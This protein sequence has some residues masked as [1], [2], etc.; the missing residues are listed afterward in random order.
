MD[1]IGIRAQNDLLVWA[2]KA[3]AKFHR[4]GSEWR[5]ACPLHTGSNAN[6]FAV[7]VDS[8]G[9]QR[10]K[11]FSGDCG[12][13]DIYDFVMKW[14][15]IEFVPAYQMLGG[16]QS[17]DPLEVARNAEQRAV[18]VIQHMEAEL[19]KYQQVLDELRSAQSW[20]A[21]HRYTLEHPEAEKLWEARGLPPSWQNFYQLGYCPAFPVSTETGRMTTPSLTIP[22]FDP[23]WQVLNIRH[24]LLNPPQPN[25]KYR[26]ERPG[27]H[28]TPLIGNPNKGYDHDP[29][30]VV[31]GEVKSMVTYSTLY[32]TEDNTPQVIGVPG[33]TAYR[34]IVDQL[35]GHDVYVLFDPDAEREA[36]EAARM[37]NGKV[38]TLP[39]KI[40]DAI[41][42][43]D[44]TA[45]GLRC[46]MKAAR[47][48]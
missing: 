19:A 24:R 38:M 32:Q 42:H 43:G 30:L 41:L 1:I 6:A 20:L 5:S 3:G 21:Y 13:G 27:L 44:L 14:Q 10:W 40:D 16:E 33:K 9:D 36:E 11:C 31:E 7:Y 18:R 34:A 47:A 4:C 25:D 29:I 45:K 22:I 46:R 23:Q 17:P 8:K 15:R 35:Q 12:Q 39:V 37:V 28:A 48:A 2:E 26:P